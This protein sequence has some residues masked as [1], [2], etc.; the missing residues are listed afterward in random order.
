MMTLLDLVR[1]KKRQSVLIHSACDGV[2]MA[3]IQ[4]CQMIDAE[5]YATLGTDKKVNY[6]TK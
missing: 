6:L 1:L 4:V 2:G 5:V 3:T